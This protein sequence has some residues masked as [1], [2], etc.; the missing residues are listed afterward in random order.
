MNTNLGQQA[1][2]LYFVEKAIRMNKD[3]QMTQVLNQ[4]HIMVNAT[5]STFHLVGNSEDMI[6]QLNTLEDVEAYDRA[7]KGM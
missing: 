6:A 7:M 2:L 1:D 4:I 3:S 5:D